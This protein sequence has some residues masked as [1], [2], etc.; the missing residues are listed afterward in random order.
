MESSSSNSEPL[1]CKVCKYEY[2]ICKNDQLKWDKGFTAH[3]WGST[4]FIATCMCFTVAGTWAII[5][6]YEN[7]YV[8]MCSASVAL[9]I[10]YICL[11]YVK[12]FKNSRS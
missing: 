11:R 8:R 12:P 5:Q 2:E 4:V 6:L 9:L 10:L 1:K 7:P 3:H